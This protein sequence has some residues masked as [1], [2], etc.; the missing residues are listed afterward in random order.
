MY[1]YSGNV[2]IDN[3]IPLNETLLLTCDNGI[4]YESQCSRNGNMRIG[5]WIPPL[6]CGMFFSPLLVKNVQKHNFFV[7]LKL[8]TRLQ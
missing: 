3:L 6:T 5:Q 7:S 1:E 2:T 4:S 8:E